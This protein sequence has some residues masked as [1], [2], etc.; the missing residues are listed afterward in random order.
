M[1]KALSAAQQ[2]AE[3]ESSE[4]LYWEL[5]GLSKILEGSGLIDESR[6]PDAYTT[7]LDAM[8]FIRGAQPVV[9]EPLTL[10]AINAMAREYPAEDLCGWSYRMG[11]ADAEALHGIKGGHHGTE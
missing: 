11:I 7:I 3:R 4:D 10:E 8:A 1:W 2:P 9:R 6:N 5:H